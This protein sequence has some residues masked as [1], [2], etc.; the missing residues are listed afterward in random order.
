MFGL[1]LSANILATFA[2]GWG[3]F[4]LLFYQFLL[5]SNTKWPLTSFTLKL[6]TCAQDSFCEYNDEMIKKWYLKIK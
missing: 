1:W 3:F 4:L 6:S 2:V 5:P